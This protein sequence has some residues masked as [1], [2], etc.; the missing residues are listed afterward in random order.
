MIEHVDVIF[1]EQQLVKIFRHELLEEARLCPEQADGSPGREVWSRDSRLEHL[2]K[3]VIESLTSGML[4]ALHSVEELVS[5][6]AVLL[7]LVSHQRALVCSP[8]Q[9]D[10]DDLSPPPPLPLHRQERGRTVR[11]ASDQRA[12]LLACDVEDIRQTVDVGVVGLSPPPR[13]LCALVLQSKAANSHSSPL[14]CK[15]LVTFSSPD[16]LAAFCS[17]P[18]AVYDLACS[19]ADVQQHGRRGGDGVLGGVAWDQD[20]MLRQELGIPC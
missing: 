18:K 14:L 9:V 15:P 4:A 12:H 2:E 13:L 17:S 5:F 1:K 6:D 7:Q 11:S 20:A 16:I 19:A 3:R 10:N 8:G